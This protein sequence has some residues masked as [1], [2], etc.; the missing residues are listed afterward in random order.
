MLLESATIYRFRLPFW[1]PLILKDHRLETRQGLILRLKTGNGQ[2]GL[3][4]CSPLPGFSP[5]SLDDAQWQLEDVLRDLISQPDCLTTV[6]ESGAHGC[7][8]RMLFSSVACAV[9]GAALSLAGQFNVAPTSTAVCPLLMGTPDEVLAQ[10]ARLPNSA[11][12]KLKVGR[13]R[14]GDDIAVVNALCEQASPSLRIRLDANRQWSFADAERFCCSVNAERIA[15][16]EEPLTD[17][18]RLSELGDLTRFPLALDESLQVPD[19]HFSVFPGLEALVIKPML[20]GGIV[21]AQQLI[22]Q[23]REANLRAI[24]SASYESP[25]GIRQLACLA[26]R[27]T[28]GE[29][30]GLDTV[31]AFCTSSVE[32]FEGLLSNALSQQDRV[33]EEVWRCTAAH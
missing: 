22:K 14:L 31:N 12:I 2:L 20:A 13:A 18:R 8:K 16:L 17:Y 24:I 3:G 28:P 29:L 30:P 33:L 1:Q 21:K 7:I 11:E 9:E 4:E 26:H 19:W 27:E 25:L 23:A 15:F 6:I 32:R 5:E 10:F